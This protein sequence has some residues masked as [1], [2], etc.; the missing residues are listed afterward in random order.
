MI[1][2]NVSMQHWS[3][4]DVITEQ[5]RVSYQTSSCNF[6]LRQTQQMT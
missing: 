1:M 2:K 6:A 3:T 4:I 5:L